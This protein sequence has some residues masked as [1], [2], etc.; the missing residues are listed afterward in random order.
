MKRLVLA[1]AFLLV[2]IGAFAQKIGHVSALEVIAGMPEKKSADTQMEALTKKYEADIKTKET[3][4]QNK[5][6]SLQEKA[7]TATQ[8]QVTQWQTE[9][10][11]EGQEIEKLKVQAYQAV[12]KKRSELLEPI[13]NKAQAAIDKIAKAQGINYVLDSSRE[14]VIIFENG[15]NDLTGAV[16]KELGIQ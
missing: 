12:E 13:L 7:K 10:Q 15:G 4:F 5:L 3:A 6:K 11:K 1:T 2:G 9:M 16:K 8:D 14:G